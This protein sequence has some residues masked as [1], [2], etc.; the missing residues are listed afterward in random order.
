MNINDIELAIRSGS[1]LIVIE[2]DEEYRVLD[3]IFDNCKYADIYTWTP[4]SALRKVIDP[5]AW[6]I[7]RSKGGT[8]SNV[9]GKAIHESPI[10]PIVD[11]DKVPITHSI[12]VIDYIISQNPDSYNLWVMRHLD[13]SQDMGFEN[14]RKIKDYYP[15][16]GKNTIIVVTDNANVHRILAR[17]YTLIQYSL[18]NTRECNLW[19]TSEIDNVIVL[20]DDNPTRKVWV[21]GKDKPIKTAYKL[22]YTKTEIN[23]IAGA[24]TGLTQQ[25]MSTAFT[26]SFKK[27]GRLDQ[28]T[29]A[30]TKRTIVEKSGLLEW[31]TPANMDE[32][33][34][35]EVLKEFLIRRKGAINSTEAE[36]YGL[37]YPKGAI[38]LGL[39]GSG[40]YSII[41]PPLLVMIMVERMNSVK[42]PQG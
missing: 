35:L 15:R 28:D 42:V 24:M 6:S 17:D 34:G 25:E 21:N 9:A 26:T 19:L 31:V 30:S 7:D 16:F 5:R 22:K 13:I 14:A 39:P 40:T 27:L 29:I 18:M 23:N 33:G 10:E 41:V 2:T 12:E 3:D 37:P 11:V 1:K 20:A 38:L 8:T 36:K 32:V 4:T